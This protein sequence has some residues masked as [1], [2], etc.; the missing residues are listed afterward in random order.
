[1]YTKNNYNMIK[2]DTTNF[3]CIENPSG[4]ISF[5]CLIKNATLRK[6]LLE[7]WE[8]TCS[9]TFREYKGKNLDE[10]WNNNTFLR[11]LFKD[12]KAGRKVKAIK[13]LCKKHDLDYNSV[14]EDLQEI[15]RE[16]KRF[17]LLQ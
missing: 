3:I 6:S 2:N 7:A 12:I 14:I 5:Q 13:E 1:M 9:L 15:R 10:P 11:Q 8:D 16:I 4:T 17:G